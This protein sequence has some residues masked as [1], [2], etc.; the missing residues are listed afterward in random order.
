ME[1]RNRSLPPSPDVDAA[2]A[3]SAAPKSP[4]EAAATSSFSRRRGGAA[5]DA[6]GE[7][8]PGKSPK[9]PRARSRAA[10]AGDGA[11]DGAAAVGA[12]AT[13]NLA[14][15]LSGPMLSARVSIGCLDGVPDV[16]FERLC[17]DGRALT[18]KNFLVKLWRYTIVP[19]KELYLPWM[20]SGLPTNYLMLTY[21]TFNRDFGLP[22]CNDDYLAPL[23][24]DELMPER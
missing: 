18:P 21:R 6:N 11:S 4:F 15:A 24:R 20:F 2:K 1:L 9:S 19:T 10:A 3:K 5:A 16:P 17:H 14:A 13:R 12:R 23:L 22:N 8:T 7:G